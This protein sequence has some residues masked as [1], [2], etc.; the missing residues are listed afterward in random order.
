MLVKGA[1]AIVE[2][3]HAPLQLAHGWVIIPHRN[4]FGLSTGGVIKDWEDFSK[5][6][7]DQYLNIFMFKRSI[8]F[9]L[10]YDWFVSNYS[11]INAK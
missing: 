2:I 5:K 7:V 6:L 1:T 10:F 8:P 4:L 9:Y 3:N 11:V